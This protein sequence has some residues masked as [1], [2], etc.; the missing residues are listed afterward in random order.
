MLLQHRVGSANL[1]KLLSELVQDLEVGTCDDEVDGRC[2]R[3]HHIHAHLFD[4]HPT[5]AGNRAH[6]LFVDTVN[7]VPNEPL[8]LFPFH[9]SQH[10]GSAVDQR[11]L[12]ASKIR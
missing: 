2:R 5:D 11:H 10:E 8:A 1:Q 12:V 7:D 9:K 4:L 3:R 6:R